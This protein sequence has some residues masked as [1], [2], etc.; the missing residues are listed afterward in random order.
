MSKSTSQ[1]VLRAIILLP[2]FSVAS[3]SGAAPQ[4]DPAGRWENDIQRF[5][6]W[7]AQN[8]W[9]RD[10]VLFVGSSSIRM[11]KTRESFADL[12]VLNRG[13][14]GSQIP[15]VLHFLDRIVLKYRPAV[16]VFY[17][18]DND[19][20]AGRS[21]EQVLGDWRTFVD[22]VRGVLPQTQIA[23]LG[24]KP[25]GAR[26]HL[27]REMDRANRL[28]HADCDADRR[29]WYVDTAKPLLKDGRPDDTV[30]LADRLHLSPAGYRR[31]TRVLRPVLDGILRRP[32]DRDS[33]SKDSGQR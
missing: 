17:C 16:I 3:V 11:W 29:L 26:W 24:I 28:I 4:A 32:G 7:D 5:E 12:P 27:W 15:D 19:I 9:P 6:A 14:G 25:S 23:Y 31:W 10:G 2:C 1:I 20:A 21:P 30:F 22:R 13:F 33:S 18:G 8:A